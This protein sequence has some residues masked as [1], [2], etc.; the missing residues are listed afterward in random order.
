MFAPSY[1]F[2]HVFRRDI[3]SP[4]CPII[5]CYCPKV[6]FFLAYSWTNLPKLSINFLNLFHNTLNMTWIAPYFNCK[7]PS[8]CVHTSH[9][10]YGYPFLTLCSWQQA[11]KNP[12]YSLRHLCC[13]LHGMLASMWGENNYMCFSNM[14]NS[15]HW[16]VNIVFTK[17]GILTL[18]NIVIV[19][20]TWANLLPRSCTTQGFVASDLVQAKEWNYHYRHLVDQF[21]PL[22]MEVFGCLEKHANVLL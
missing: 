5:S 7:Y 6:N 2:Q 13:H 11:H 18:I 16:W 22:A 1:I 19:D 17:D 10:P 4:L 9:W 15:S 14:F 12:W 20:P 8:M 21:L 3:W